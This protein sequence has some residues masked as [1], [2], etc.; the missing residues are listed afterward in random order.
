MLLYL[1]DVVWNGEA[2][3]MNQVLNAAD[4]SARRWMRVLVVTKS[5]K[6]VRFDFAW[7]ILRFAGA[8]WFEHL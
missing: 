5:L 6:T 8:R 2:S 4:I 1:K 7:S 3:R